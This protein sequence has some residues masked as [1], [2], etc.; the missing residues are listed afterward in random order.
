[1]GIRDLMGDLGETYPG[2]HE[3]RQVNHVPDDEPEG[4]E[5]GPGKIMI[6]R[7]IEVEFWRIG[8]LARA[9]NRSAVTIRMWEREGI[10]PPSGWTSPGRDRDPRGKRRLWTRRQI[11][12]VWRIARDEGILYP[13]PHVSILNTRF[14][15]RVTAMF[16]E[17][18]KAAIK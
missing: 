10:L 2:S 3:K 5:L 6:V 16:A 11:E 18:R 13:G 12:G 15:E 4:P 9:L 14:T 1:M 8:T 17:L 7:G